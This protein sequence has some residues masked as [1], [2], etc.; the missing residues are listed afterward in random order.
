[1]KILSDYLKLGNEID[2]MDA[3]DPLLDL[4]ANYFINIKRI[5][6]TSVDEFK[7][8]YDKINNFFK[9]IGILLANSKSKDDRFYREAIRKFDFPEVNGIC[10][11]YSKGNHGSGFGKELA[12][13]IIKDAKDIIDA[14]INEPEI[15]HLV[16]L[17]EENVGPDRLSDM[18][19]T[20]LEKEIEEYTKRINKQLVINPITYP[21]LDFEGEYLINPFKKGRILLLPKDILHELPIAKDWEDIDRVCC[22]I[23]A[24]R[25]DVNSI[26]GEEWKKLSVKVKKAFIRDNVMKNPILLKSL[27]DDY[28]KLGVER[29][30]FD[31]DTLGEYKV[32]RY[33]GVLASENPLEIAKNL[34][35]SLAITEKLCYKFKDLVENNKLYE[36]L[37]NEDGKPRKEKI[38]QLSFY[39][40]AEAY[41]QANDLDISPESNGGRGPVDFKMSNGYKDRTLV[42]IK[43]TTN[44]QLVHGLKTQLYEYS[45]AEK[46]EKLIYL[47]IDNGG[48]QS[49]IEEMYATYNEIK[50]AD[51]KPILVFID[52]KPKKS[53]SKY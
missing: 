33:S 31:S 51:I 18:F 14:G 13:K 42:E 48:P 43:L 4:D 30:D 10:L 35:T 15:F 49:R 29:Y 25:N 7:G 12:A 46:T 26:L 27:L 44:P 41:C 32:A 52:A 39:G 20:L 16:G 38:A 6:D 5:K 53:A 17:F 36:I 3:F 2:L 45:K 50:D 47:V 1:M 28:K 21:E 24:I 23:E 34:R 37:Y 22:E 8:A 40:I 9:G 11:G 19:A